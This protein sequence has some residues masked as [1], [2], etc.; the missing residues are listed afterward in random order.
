MKALVL[1]DDFPPTHTGGASVIAAMMADQLSREGI[2]VTVITTTANKNNVSDGK[3]GNMRVVRLYSQYPT[4]LRSYISLYNLPLLVQVKH[5]IKEVLPDIVFVHNIHQRLSYGSI[6]V[7]KKYARSVLFVAHDAMTFHYGKLFP[8]DIHNPSSLS[9]Y[10]VSAWQ[11]LRDFRFVYNPFRNIFIRWCLS[12]VTRVIA[13]SDALKGALVEN[14]INNVTVVHNGIDSSAWCVTSELASS[15][16][17]KFNIDRSKFTIFFGGRISRAKGSIAILDS[18]KLLPKEIQS[19][20]L[21]LVAGSLHEQGDHFINRMSQYDLKDRIVFLGWLN[22]DD[23]KL[24]YANSDVV[25][26]PSLC[27]DWFPTN[28]LEAMAM[29][30]PV[31]ASCWGGASEAISDKATGYIVNPYYPQEISDKIDLLINNPE[32]GQRLGVAGY[33]KVES[34][35]SSRVKLKEVLSIATPSVN[36]DDTSFYDKESAVYSEKR[37]VTSPSTYNQFFFSR[38]LKLLKRWFGDTIAYSQSE[39]IEIL[40]I[41]CADGVI[42]RKLIESYD[43]T[44]KYAVGVDISPQM[45]QQARAIN[46]NPKLRFFVKSDILEETFGLVLAVGFLS[47]PI[48]VSEFEFIKR[49][50]QPGGIIVCSIAGKYSLFAKFKL[51]NVSSAADYQSYDLCEKYF[52]QDFDIVNTFSYGIFIPKLW[53]LPKSIAYPIQVACEYLFQ[54]FPSLYHERLYILKKK[55]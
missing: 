6:L 26:V 36:F 28:I 15:F 19:K 25:V 3:E 16:R 5:V 32:L 38:R 17:K 27:Y 30:K 33:Q 20:V 14:G 23:I 11:Q 31:I 29:K 4:S 37:Y 50:L 54:I 21:L 24:A 45:V 46:H 42:L 55:Q 8:V 10:R 7:A 34:L 18:I 2:D 53:A 35:F 51:R 48:F 41:G 52:L 49:Y 12:R 47:P 39:S 43:R 1:S 9:N 40:E 13:V 44:I 22:R